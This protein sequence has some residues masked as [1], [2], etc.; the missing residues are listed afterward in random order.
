[1]NGTATTTTPL[2]LLRI[3]GLTVTQLNALLRARADDD[4]AA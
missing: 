3:A 1:M 4:R 2:D